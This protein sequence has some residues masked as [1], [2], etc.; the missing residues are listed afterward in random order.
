MRKLLATSLLPYAKLRNAWR[1]GL[2]ILMYHRVA[3]L[4]AYDQLTVSPERFAQQ[5]QEL[6]Q[7]E[8]VSLQDGLRALQ[9]GALRKPLIAV[10]FDDGYLDNLTEALP[11]LRRYRIPATIF[12]TTQFCDQA[13]RHPR[14]GSQGAQRLHLDWDEVAALAREPGITIGSHTLT[15]P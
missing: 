5:M 6:A 1:P 3:Q 4:A 10:T 7:H 2:R 8:V 9:S 15:H 12:I 13:L 14:Y 11:V